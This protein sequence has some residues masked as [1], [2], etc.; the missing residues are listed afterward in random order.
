MEAS[1]NKWSY[2]GRDSSGKVTEVVEKKEISSEATVGI[3]AWS[4]AGKMMESITY[5]K[6]INLRVNNEYYVAPTY[7]YLIKNDLTIGTVTVGKHG[8]A[9]HGLGTPNDLDQFLNHVDF[10]IFRKQVTG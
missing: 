5:L 9:V 4:T 3:Y 6:S 10:E 1:G 7:G 2:I 8:E